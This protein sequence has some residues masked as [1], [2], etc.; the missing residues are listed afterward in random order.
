MKPLYETTK[1]EGE[2]V[3]DIAGR[4]QELMLTHL[5]HLSRLQAQRYNL[6]YGITREGDVAGALRLC[7]EDLQAREETL[8][9]TAD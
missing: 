4:H 1:Y 6:T 8:G 7:N 3:I 9:E 2:P 5:D